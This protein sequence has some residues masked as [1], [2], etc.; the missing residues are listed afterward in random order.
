MPY[1]YPH[2]V[3][4]D[5]LRG[6]AI[7]GIIFAN[8]LTLGGYRDAPLDVQLYLSS[9]FLDQW[10]L[11][12]HEVFLR[13]KFYTLFSFLFGLGFA[14]FLA[15]N[16]TQQKWIR[17]YVARLAFLF[18]IGALHAWLFFDGDILRVYAMTGFCMLLFKDLSDR[19]LLIAALMILFIP[20]IISGYPVYFTSYLSA[21]L[22]FKI[23]GL[24]LLGFYLGRKRVFYRLNN[25]MSAIKR[26]LPW[27]WGISLI[28]N[29][30]Y[31][32][33]NLDMN[34]MVKEL[35]YALS[36]YPCAFTYIIT[37]IYLCRNQQEGKIAQSFA[38]VGRMSLSN[39][40]AQSILAM[41]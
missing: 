11:F 12:F 20:F 26:I 14:I 5:I 10:L 8:I 24:F 21:A 23:L 16:D 2:L 31:V 25:Y 29:I 35:A 39:Y 28:T 17:V 38:D 27:A 18:I 3:I 7:S 40:L 22:F 36:V 15:R 33:F 4:L 9:S 37:I 6:F 32:I 13:Y 19:N 30:I 34:P 1:H 41:A